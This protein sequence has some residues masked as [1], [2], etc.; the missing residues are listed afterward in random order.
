MSS[1]FDLC[2]SELLREAVTSMCTIAIIAIIFG[3]A[4]L[5]FMQTRFKLDTATFDEKD[6]SIQ[7]EPIS[8]LL[9]TKEQLAEYNCNNGT[10]R[11]L[12][13][14]RNVIYD[15][16]NLFE[17]FGPKGKY[18]KWSG[19][20]LTELIKAEAILKKRNSGELIVNADP[21]QEAEEDDIFDPFE[22]CWDHNSQ[23]LI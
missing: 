6:Y 11:Y 12:V 3:M 22:G 13:A 8:G 5:F 17:D 7:L 2:W 9:L 14:L 15:V 1:V 21:E 20:E 4:Y 18:A 19:Q 16:S 10:L 23:L